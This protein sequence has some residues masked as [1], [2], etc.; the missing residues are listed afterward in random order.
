MKNVTTISSILKP[1]KYT[2]LLWDEG[3]VLLVLE[4]GVAVAGICVRGWGCC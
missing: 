3:V 2:F 4:L 1:T